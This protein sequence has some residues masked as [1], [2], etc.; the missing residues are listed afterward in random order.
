MAYATEEQAAVILKFLHELGYD[1]PK[2]SIL[3]MDGQEATDLVEEIKK[4]NEHDALLLVRRGKDGRIHTVQKARS[5]S[6]ARLSASASSRSTHF[7][8]ASRTTRGRSK[9]QLPTRRISS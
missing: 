4:L 5:D 2:E 6:T 3:Y 9:S 7:L 1:P 8:R